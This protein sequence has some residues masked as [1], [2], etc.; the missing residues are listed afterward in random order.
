[1]DQS[2][3]L[4]EALDRSR[5]VHTQRVPFGRGELFRAQLFTDGQIQEISAQ[6][7]TVP[8]ALRRQPTA[9][10]MTTIGEPLY[11]NRHRLDYYTQCAHADNQRLYSHFSHVYERL[12][13]FFAQRYG[14]PVVYPEEL[15]VPGFHIFEFLQPG[16]YRGGSWHF[17]TLYLQVPALA[18]RRE[19]ISDVVNFTLPVQVPSGGTGMDLCDGGPGDDG[20][21]R[22]VR[23]RTP[24][25]PG[26]L[27]FNEHEYWHRIGDSRC[28]G[29]GE[30]RV[31]LQG[32]GV[33]FQGQWLLFW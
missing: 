12:A 30:R 7:D 28:L 5:A 2:S 10:G 31:T 4:N 20:Q 13:G 9:G 27:V 21:G 6:I 3:E 15:A 23:I 19:E 17:D 8:G 32:H 26:L 18:A 22:G 33:C 11:L 25:R 14:A 24:Y 29:A 1:M 16:E